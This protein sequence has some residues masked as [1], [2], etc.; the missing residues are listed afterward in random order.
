MQF[1]KKKILLLCAIALVVGGGYYYLINNRPSADTVSLVSAVKWTFTPAYSGDDFYVTIKYKYQNSTNYTEV[2]KP[3]KSLLKLNNN[4]LVNDFPVVNGLYVDT[5]KYKLPDG[6]IFSPKTVKDDNFV[7]DIQYL[8]QGNIINE[9]T[10]SLNNNA[11]TKYSTFSQQGKSSFVNVGQMD[12]VPVNAAPTPSGALS[13]SGRVMFGKR[14]SA[15]GVIPPGISVSLEGTGYPKK[16]VKTTQDPNTGMSVYLFNDL[17]KIPATYRIY[18][19][20]P[21]SDCLSNNYRYIGGN[22]DLII[23]DDDVKSGSSSYDVYIKDRQSCGQ[24]SPTTVSGEITSTSGGYAG[25]V[26]IEA[27]KTKGQLYKTAQSGSPKC[28]CDNFT[29]SGD[30]NL[31]PGRYYIKGFNYNNGNTATPTNSSRVRDGEYYVIDLLSGQK[32]EDLDFTI[33]K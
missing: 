2:N 27:D 21:S 12:I 6:Y 5:I 15:V 31:E 8:G 23:T 16:T 4:A 1:T 19:A 28:N 11:I 13:L 9:I 30:N 25:G 24:M 32:I 18:I 29:F 3:F 22:M 10:I 17:P 26:S 33:V 14:G 7:Q 20:D